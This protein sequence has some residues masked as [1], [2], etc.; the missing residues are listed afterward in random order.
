MIGISVMKELNGCHV[1][2]FIL[3]YYEDLLDVLNK[4]FAKAHLE[5]N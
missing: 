5:P 4:M 2:I 1:N 3:I